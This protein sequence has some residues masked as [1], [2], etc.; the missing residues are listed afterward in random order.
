[1]SRGGSKRP[2][3]KGREG[4]VEEKERRER[5]KEDQRERVMS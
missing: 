5:G 1:M 3:K 2:G 4:G